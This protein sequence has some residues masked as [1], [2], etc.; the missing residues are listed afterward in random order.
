MALERWDIIPWVYWQAANLGPIFGN[1]LSYTRYM[2]DV[3]PLKKAHPLERFGSEAL[4]LVAV[5]DKKLGDAPYICGDDFTIADIASYPWIRGYKWS[6]ID[7][8][9]RPRVVAWMARVRASIA[10]TENIKGSIS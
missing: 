3:D 10:A 8:T 9:T 1:K 6:K 5:L 7:I 2:Q 4:R